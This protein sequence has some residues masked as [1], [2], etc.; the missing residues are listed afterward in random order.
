MNGADAWTRP[1]DL[2]DQVRRLW[3]AGRILSARLDGAPLF[4]YR[5]RLQRPHA[6]ALGAHFDEV[7]A[8]IRALEEASRLKAGFGYD[9]EWTEINHRQLGRN[10]VPDG[11]V[12]PTETDALRLIGKL[13]EA[14]RFSDLAE[15]TLA[16]FPALATWLARRPFTVLDHAADWERILAILGW[17]R[18]HP[19]S[20][21]YVRQI[22][23]AGVDTKFIEARKGLLSELLDLVLVR[24]EGD[25]PPAGLKN[26]EPRYG[27]RAKPPLIRFRILDLRLA[28]RGLTDIS[29]PPHELAALAPPVRR[30]F[31]TEN[32]INGLAFPPVA[33][34]LVIFGLG[35]GIDLLAGL[36][37]MKRLAVHYW[38]DIDTHGFAMLDRFRAAFPSAASLL[39]DRET[40][41]AHRAQWGE[42]AVQ[43]PGPLARLDPAEQA[44]FADL[45]SDRLGERVRLEQER[46]AFGRVECALQDILLADAAGT[47]HEAAP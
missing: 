46:I 35:Y 1:K 38:G 5:L 7:R 29:V 12:V 6:G 43:H 15:T 41:L 21:L 36:D 22:D 14:D 10:R 11:A 17:F 45:L 26:F 23:I 32:E 16:A 3:N 18:D 13:R 34:A 40:L 44:L 2:A 28:I 42:E 31:V 25:A 9:I 8:W 37:W 30:V 4:P 39:M 47:S 33:D 24:A 27:L 20:G 19:D